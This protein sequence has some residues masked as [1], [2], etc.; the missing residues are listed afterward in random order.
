MKDEDNENKNLRSVPSAK[1]V[2]RLRYWGASDFRQS[3]ETNY[4]ELVRERKALANLGGRDVIIL[5]SRSGHKVRALLGFT[6]ELGKTRTG[7]TRT[8]FETI[9][10]SLGYGTWSDDMVAD[11]AEMRGI[12]LEGI[13]TM[14][15]IKRKLEESSQRAVKKAKGAS[16]L[17]AAA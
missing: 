3:G 8:V 5:H 6:A 13:K 1:W 16:K 9:E 7:K 17:K 10:W 14:R 4:E 15:E 11:Y 2:L 12:K